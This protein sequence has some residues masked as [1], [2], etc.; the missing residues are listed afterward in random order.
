MKRISLLFLSFAL[1][2]SCIAPA[3][4]EE[5]RL[6]WDM[7]KLSTLPPD[8]TRG[9]FGFDALASI[10]DD[11]SWKIENSSQNSYQSVLMPCSFIKEVDRNFTA[12]IESVASRKR[13]TKTWVE[14]KLG[15]T[16][17]GEPVTT[18]RKGN[19]YVG[20]LDFDSKNLTPTGDK[21]T[22]WTLIGR[23]HSSGED[24]L[25]R[26][27]FFGGTNSFGKTTLKVELIPVFFERT[28][29]TVTQDKL[30]VEEF[31][32]DSEYRVR[33]RTGV[34]IKTLTGWFFGRMTAPTVDRNGP[35]GYLEISG[36]PA[37]IPIGLTNIVDTSEACKYFDPLRKTK[38]SNP[39]AQLKCG[40]EKLFDKAVT[41]TNSEGWSPDALSRWE[42]APGGVK[43][44]ATISKWSLDSTGWSGLSMDAAA[45]TCVTALYGVNARVFQGAVFSNATL[46]QIEPPNWNEQNQSFEFQVA[47]PHLDEN[48]ARNQGFYTLYIPKEFAKCR[49]GELAASPRAEVQVTN[50]NG[51]S[52]AITV[53]ATTE[54]DNLRFNIEGFGYSSP[55]IKI[56]LV[57]SIATEIS[58]INSK[59]ASTK[60]VLTIHCTKGKLTRK[61]TNQKPTCPSGF[62]IKK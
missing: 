50:S 62:K 20:K 53:V 54:N 37:R 60:K 61:I 48:G 35:A 51:Q 56:R 8:K 22:L 59:V 41:F 4:A 30:F 23:R 10:Q 33:I 47:S 11:Y 15:D 3:S 12:C 29:A 40:E 24:Y 2:L 57:N 44:V 39:S 28:S 13:G 46:F 1:F 18:I 16:Q 43:S 31:P 7:G 49:W 45:D 26:A 17:L 32:K 34:F 14:A 52:T 5:K 36:E 19:L 25:V 27:R 55:I 58:P 9:L 38:V 6:L 42:E 21:A